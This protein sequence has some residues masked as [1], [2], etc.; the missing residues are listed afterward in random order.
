[1]APLPGGGPCSIEDDHAPGVAPAR[2]V[3]E[4]LR[5][6]VDAVASRDELVQLELAALVE[7]DQPREV[8]A[9]A[10]RAVVAALERLLLD[11]QADRAQLGEVG[12]PWNADHH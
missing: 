12:G 4:G 7:R 2:Q 11:H 1:M 5:R 9:R 3:L 6:L 10:G 8:V